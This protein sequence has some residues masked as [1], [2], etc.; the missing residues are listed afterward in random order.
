MKITFDSITKRYGEVIANNAVTLDIESGSVHAII[1]ENGAGKSTL[2][3]MLSGQITPDSGYIRVDDRVIQGFSTQNA[4]EL[5][6]GLLGQDPMDFRNLTVM[7]SFTVGHRL[8]SKS[9]SNRVLREDFE[10]LNS[11]YT[12][13]IDYKK[14]IHQLS[15]GERQQVELMRLLS[16]G[17]KVIILDEP[18]SGF[19]TEQKNKVFA[20]LTELTYQGCTVVL[21][22]HKLEDVLEYASSV[23]VMRKGVLIDTLLLPQE[24]SRLVDLMFGENQE[25]QIPQSDAKT[26]EGDIVVNVKDSDGVMEFPLTKGMMVGTIGLQGSGVD[27]F[28]RDMFFN[29]SFSVSTGNKLIAK[30]TFGYV[31]TDRLEKGLFPEL[32]ILDHHALSH[33]MNEGVIEWD[34]TR[35]MCEDLIKEYGIIGTPNTRARELSGGNQQRLMLSMLRDDID[36]AMLEHP[37][38]GLDLQSADYIWDKLNKDKTARILTMFSSYDIDEILAHADFV[39]CFHGEEIVLSGHINSL[40]RSDI[41][42]SISG[43][44]VD[45]N[46]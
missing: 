18:N 17:A 27:R 13:N 22:S 39:I 21:V 38:R 16:N 31:P 26:S 41:V 44:L 9:K 19:S 15:V 3:K 1:G 23:T 35:I 14:K 42:N 11:K 10:N 28:L 2:V 24:P 40:S 20:A 43:N 45:V 29:K 37:T 25:K 7:Q 6:I 33:S 30:S 46:E 12:F 8:S 36:V 5:G 34:R 4:I 32:T